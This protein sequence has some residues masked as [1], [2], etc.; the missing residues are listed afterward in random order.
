MAFTLTTPIHIDAAPELANRSA[1]NP[2]VPLSQALWDDENGV[3]FVG[4][5]SSG[6]RVNEKR[7]LG[8]SSIWRAVNLI[9]RRLGAMPLK[10]FRSVGRGK[11]VDATHPA[12]KLLRRKPNEWMTAIVFK[13]T[14]QAS[15]LLRGNGYAYITRDRDG[16]PVELLPLSAENTWPMRRNGRLWYVTQVPRPDG[17]PGEV[18]VLEHTDVLHIRGLGFDGLVGHDVVSILRETIGKAIGTR[19]YSARF[20]QNNARPSVA[21]EF[22]SG[23]KDA[24]IQNVV[25]RWGAMNRGLENAHKIGVLREGIKLNTYSMNAR[26]SQLL[27]NLTFDAVDVANIF[28]LPPRKLG[29]DQGGGYNSIYEE[30]QSIDDDTMEPHWVTWEEECSDKLL[31]E[32]EK[33]T[34]SHSCLFVRNAVMRANPGER[35]DYYAKMWQMGAMSQDEIRAFEDQNPLPDGQG[36]RYFVPLNYVAS[37]AVGQPTDPAP[38]PTPAPTPTVDTTG[39]RAA[40]RVALAD[41]ARRMARR[42][43]TQ[44]ERA[45]KKNLGEW[46]DGDQSHN[47]RAIREAFSPLLS[48]ARASG[49][50]FDENENTFAARFLQLALSDM[51]APSFSVAACGDTFERELSEDVSRALLPE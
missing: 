24:V 7:A 12:H 29:L 9:S 48:A 51:S 14:L 39:L 50:K 25:E 43:L 46:I 33:A 23:M 18:R 16:R 32:E 49:A 10:V 31:T 21:L 8:Y 30:N 5:T 2:A 6:V 11:E 19:D 3:S 20:F 13:Q 40:L 38:E 4:K 26:D 42:L 35:A 36:N 22:P 45:E 47:L 37:D 27:E 17:G 1:E 15:A 28:G 41:T 34:E 44:A